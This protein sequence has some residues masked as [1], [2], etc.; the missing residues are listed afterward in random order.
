MVAIPSRQHALDRLAYIGS[1]RPVPPPSLQTREIE[2]KCLSVM[3]LLAS[4]DWFDLIRVRLASYV[5][6][7]AYKLLVMRLCVGRSA[8]PGVF[9][10][11]VCVHALKGLVL[12]HASTFAHVVVTET[13][14]G[15]AM[16]PTRTYCL[17]SLVLLSQFCT[18]S[19][20]RLAISEH[21]CF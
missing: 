4:I 9:S 16:S 7:V 5:L 1:I 12:P 21:Q 15:R 14:I 20:N 18:H 17:R 19:C 6:L 2:C 10:E 8:G 11:A 13:N 3:C